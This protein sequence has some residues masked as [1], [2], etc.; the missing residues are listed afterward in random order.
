MFKLLNPNLQTK[1]QIKY[2]SIK[3]ENRFNLLK[4]KFGKP[5]IQLEISR[6]NWIP[7]DSIG[8]LQNQLEKSVLNYETLI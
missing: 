5:N 1:S 3:M 8:D 4:F 2:I 6:L 7:L